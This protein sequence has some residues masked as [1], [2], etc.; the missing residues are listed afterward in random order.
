LSIL[1]TIFS[2]TF[3]FYGCKFWI[4]L[5]FVLIFPVSILWE[6]WLF[7]KILSGIHGFIW[8]IFQDWS[9]LGYEFTS[10]FPYLKISKTTRLTFV[11]A[12]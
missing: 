12:F 5:N 8:D 9:L 6:F 4:S 2:Y 10:T 3:R 1:A 7:F 11:R